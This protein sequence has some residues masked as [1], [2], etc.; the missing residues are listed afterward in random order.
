MNYICFMFQTTVVSAGLFFS[1]KLIYPLYN[2]K[3]AAFLLLSPP[4]TGHKTGFPLPKK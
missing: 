3:T 4:H 1:R 2:S